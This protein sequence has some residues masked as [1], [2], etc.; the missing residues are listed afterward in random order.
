MSDTRLQK[1]LLYSELVEGKRSRYVCYVFSENVGKEWHRRTS[2]ARHSHGFARCQSVVCTPRLAVSGCVHRFRTE[3]VL[4]T[5]G[6]PT[7]AHVFARRQHAE[8][9]KAGCDRRF[10]WA[11]HLVRMSDTRLQKRLLYSELVEGKRSRYVCYVFSENVG[12]EWHR[13]TS[14][15]RH[16]HGFARCQSVVCT[17]RLAVS[18]CVHRFRTEAVL[19]THGCPTFAHVFARR[20]HAEARKAGCDRR[21]RWAGHLVRMSDTRLQKRLLYSELVEGKRSRVT[22]THVTRTSLARFRKV[23]ECGLHATSGSERL[24]ASYVAQVD[25]VR[26]RYLTRTDAL[27]LPTFLHVDSTQEH[28]RRAVT[29]ALRETTAQKRSAWRS[30]INRGVTTYEQTRIAEAVR[31][32]ASRTISTSLTPATH[33]YPTCVRAFNAQ[34]AREDEIQKFIQE[35]DTTINLKQHI[36]L[37]G[38]VGCC[39][40]SHPPYLVTKYMRYGDLKGFLLK[41]RK[42]DE[43]LRDSMYDFNEMEIYQV[44]R[45][46]ANGMTFISQAG[47]VHGDLAA[48]NVLVGEDL[49]VKISDFGLT[50]DI[51][52]RGYQRQDAEQK[53]PLRWMAPER[54]LREGRYTTKSDVWSFGVVLY[55]IATLGNVPYPGRERTLLD[56]LRTGYRE[57]RPPGL[58]QELYDMMLRCWQWEEDDRPEFDELYEELDAV[59]ESMANYYVKPGTGSPVGGQNEAAEATENSYDVPKSARLG[60]QLHVTADVHSSED[61]D[62]VN[63][64]APSNVESSSTLIEKDVDTRNDI[65]TTYKCKATQQEALVKSEDNLQVKSS[66]PSGAVLMNANDSSI[67]SELLAANAQENET[68]TAI[69]NNSGDA[70]E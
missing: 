60:M 33:L 22:S 44:A 6:C 24:R 69:E 48:R 20:Q 34:N 58:K 47:Y 25:S 57:P 23:S 31:T 19:T 1:R 38:L 46:I 17:P 45:Q 28:V 14:L 36:N 54:L 13:R 41:C 27:R 11:G 50:T 61:H 67:D 43:R 18:G 10:R 59:V 66:M 70:E 9:R 68:Q 35:V 29:V 51:Y 32:C 52:E 2:L 63:S 39:T 49:V 30:H 65:N 55:E 26:R 12:K 4:T 15:A 8:A 42:L 16:S 53:I 56:E 62:Y 5:H 64:L 3:A 37:L 7:F 40:V 21:F